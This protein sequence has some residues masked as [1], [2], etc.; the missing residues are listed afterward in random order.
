MGHGYQRQ[1]VAGGILLEDFVEDGLIL[2]YFVLCREVCEFAVLVEVANL[3]HDRAVF[4]SMQ[5]FGEEGLACLDEAFALREIKQFVELH[6]IDLLSEFLL[7][8]LADVGCYLGYT[9]HFGAK[10]GVF[11]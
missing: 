4:P 8:S 2:C 1:R 3:R 7:V 11:R 5:L 10:I 9:C 6:F